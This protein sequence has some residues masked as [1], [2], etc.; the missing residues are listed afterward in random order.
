[1]GNKAFYSFHRTNNINYLPLVYF[2]PAEIFS[3]CPT[4]CK[5]PRCFGEMAESDSMLNLIKSDQFFVE[6][7]DAVAAMTFPHFGFRGWKEHYTGDFP[8]WK[9][10]YYLP[11]WVKLLEEETG[12]GLQMLFASSTTDRIPFIDAEF[13]TVTMSRVVHRAIEEQGWQPM[14]DVIKEMPC[15]E[16]F[17]KV[18][19]RVRIDFLRKW[20]HTRAER[21]KTVSLEQSLEDSRNDIYTLEGENAHFVTDIV[22]EDYIERLKTQLSE[23]DLKILEL[24]VEGRTY[25][26]I[27]RIMGYKNHSGIIKRIRAISA[28]YEDYEDENSHIC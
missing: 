25:E 26:E 8:V 24:R 16:D 5:I 10:S 23:K 20:Y 11:L 12:W 7:A 15:D 22:S 18:H 21:V 14:L 27:A 17:E 13:A 2:L 1:M 19:S 28:A 3:A 9:L 6:T 4:L